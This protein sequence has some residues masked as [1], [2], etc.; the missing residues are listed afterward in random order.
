M[1]PLPTS[2]QIAA[3]AGDSAKP[4]MVMMCQAR[5]MG[6][7]ST[8]RTHRIPSSFGLAFFHN[9]QGLIGRGTGPYVSLPK[10]EHLRTSH[11]R[12]PLEQVALED[13]WVDFLTLMA[14]DF[15]P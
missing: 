10:L 9:A 15:L 8:S 1:S 2:P 5:L 14:Y 7:P 4:G 3:A 11:A 13:G 12:R 6:K